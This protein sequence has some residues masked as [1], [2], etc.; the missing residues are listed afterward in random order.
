[1][2]F[3]ELGDTRGI[4]IESNHRER[5]I[6]RTTRPRAIRHSPARSR[7]FFARVSSKPAPIAS[8]PTEKDSTLYIIAFVLQ[9]LKFFNQGLK[10]YIPLSLVI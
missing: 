1:M 3:S 2:A 10:Y 9:K 5:P 6:G 4:N 7:R 8:I